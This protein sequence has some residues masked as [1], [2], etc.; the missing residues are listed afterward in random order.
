MVVAAKTIALTAVDLFQK[1]ELIAQG[2]AELAK[3][4]GGAEF[5]YEALIGDRK[6]ALDY[7]N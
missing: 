6:P 2:K 7:R 3:R 5:K 1:P 4:R